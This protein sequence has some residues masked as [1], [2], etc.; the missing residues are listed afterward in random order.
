MIDNEDTNLNIKE[1]LK[2][3]KPSVEKEIENY[4]PKKAEEMV[5]NAWEEV[6]TV[7]PETNAKIILIKFAE[8]LV[9]RKI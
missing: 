9:D 2:K 3:Y 4:I 5:E 7:L 6:D 8:Y 1:F